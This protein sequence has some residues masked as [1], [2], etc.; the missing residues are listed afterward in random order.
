M[1]FD[2]MNRDMIGDDLCARLQQAGLS[3]LLPSFQHHREVLVTTNEWIDGTIAISSIKNTDVKL[4]LTK[5]LK[6]LR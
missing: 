3:K 1:W 4:E 6:T 2:F 5:Y